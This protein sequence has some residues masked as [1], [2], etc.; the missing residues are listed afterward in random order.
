MLDSTFVVRRFAQNP[1]S[2]VTV[3]TGTFR[4]FAYGE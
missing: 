3:R 2:I 1:S 4:S